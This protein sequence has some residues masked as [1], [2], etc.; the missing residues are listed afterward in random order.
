MKS[1][2]N[3]KNWKKN[4]KQLRLSLRVSSLDILTIEIDIPRNFYMI[5]V[6]NFTL[7][8]R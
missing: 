7:K 3:W 2:N 6:F 8:N 4:L 5:T 1:R